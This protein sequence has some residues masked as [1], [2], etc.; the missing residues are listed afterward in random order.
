MFGNHIVELTGEM[1]VAV[2][3][4]ILLGLKDIIL[5]V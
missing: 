5:A 1:L 3:R 4:V 2:D